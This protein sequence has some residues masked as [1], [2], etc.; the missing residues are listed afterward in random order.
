MGM[1]GALGTKEKGM[2]YWDGKGVVSEGQNVRRKERFNQIKWK[3][4]VLYSK[5]FGP[6]ISNVD[7]C[8]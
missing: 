8:V 3:G 5:E 2:C 4:P 6:D 7:M 1:T